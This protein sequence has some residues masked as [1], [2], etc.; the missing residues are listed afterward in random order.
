MR[1]RPS[2][3]S[4]W[5]RSGSAR[6]SRI[7]RESGG[8]ARRDAKSADAVGNQGA[9]AL[10][11]GGD[12]RHPEGHRRGQGA[13]HRR[14]Q[15]W[16]AED[17]EHAPEPQTNHRNARE[18]DP[19]GDFQAVST[20]AEIHLIGPLAGDHELGI[21]PRV[22]HLPRRVQEGR[23]P[24]ARHQ[25]PGRADDRQATTRG[26]DP[27]RV[28]VGNLDPRV[29]DRDPRGW[30]VELAG[31]VIGQLAAGCDQAP[32]PAPAQPESAPGGY[33]FV[34]RLNVG[35]PPVVGDGQ[36]DVAEPRLQDVAKVGIAEPLTEPEPAN[37]QRRSPAPAQ[38]GAID[39]PII[40][41]GLAC[42]G[43][44]EH[45]GD[46]T[47]AFQAIEERPDRP[48]LIM[49]AQTACHQ[50]DRTDGFGHRSSSP[51]TRRQT[52]R[53]VGCWLQ[54]HPYPGPGP[55]TYHNQAT[56][57]RGNPATVGGRWNRSDRSSIVKGGPRRVRRDRY[58][59]SKD[60]A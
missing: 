51:P 27:R 16:L 37:R 11:V 5:A 34:D 19:V 29:H 50:Q 30:D 14:N 18:R 40:A 57:G 53:T 52:R 21:D 39:H 2:A 35:N 47:Q 46:P 55:A 4:F 44:T 33:E 26:R 43:D 49:D 58:R 56:R 36:A 48:P 13:C 3:P 25:G 8:V 9:K 23:E 59:V 12:H 45:L 42:R 1:A 32:A 28:V 38:P 15:R 17:V 6:S 54:G 24:R 41:R 10:D 20:T 7:E 31:E 22:D 60:I